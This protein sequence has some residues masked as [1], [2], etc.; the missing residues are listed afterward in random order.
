M[1]AADATVPPKTTMSK[2]HYLKIVNTIASWVPGG[3]GEDW[4]GDIFRDV[5]R[6]G[7]KLVLE[8]LVPNDRGV[9]AG[10]HGDRFYVEVGRD[11]ERGDALFLMRVEYA[12]LP[13]R[14]P[15]H[16][17]RRITLWP[18]GAPP[19]L[20]D[21]GDLF[22]VDDAHETVRAEDPLPE[23]TPLLQR[24]LA[25][26]ASTLRVAVRP[27]TDVH[28]SPAPETFLAPFRQMWT[29]HRLDRHIA[30]TTREGM[31][32]K[33]RT[34]PG[35]LARD[36]QGAL[37]KHFGVTLLNRLAAADP[38]VLPA[39]AEGLA[40][41]CISPE[42]RATLWACTLEGLDCPSLRRELHESSTAL[43]E[44]A[45]TPGAASAAWQRVTVPALQHLARQVDEELLGVIESNGGTEFLAVAQWAADLVFSEP[46]T[47]PAPEPPARDDGE[48]APAATPAGQADIVDQWVLGLRLPETAEV[49]GALQTLRDTA[50]ALGATPLPLQSID[51]LLRFD[52]DASACQDAI[53]KWAAAVGS[54]AA[55]PADLAEA[56]QIYAAL[57]TAAGDDA[58]SVVQERWI[59]PE[60]VAGIV[61]L[62]ERPE[63]DAVPDWLLERHSGSEVMARPATR[64]DWAERLSESGLRDDVRLFIDLYGSLNEPGAVKWMV[65]AQP[66]DDVTAHLH[67][68]HDEVRAFLDV[69]SPELRGMVAAEHGTL[70]EARDHGRRVEAL[71]SL[72]A[73]T[74]WTGVDEDLRAAGAT[75][76]APL[77][78]AYE[79]A[80]DFLRREIGLEDLGIDA[81][82]RRVAREQQ[83]RAQDATGQ[84]PA[85]AAITVQHNFVD[86]AAR[87]TLTEVPSN[88]HPYATIVVP[89]I[90]EA[91]QPGQF[92][93]E[94]EFVFADGVR[95]LWPSDWPAPTPTAIDV[96]P[97]KWRPHPT[98]STWQYGFSAQF[99][100]RRPTGTRRRLKVE[101]RVFEAGSRRPLGPP[102]TLEWESFVDELRPIEMRWSE[103]NEPEHV[104]AHP[105][106]PQAKA[107]EILGRFGRG[108]S[109]VVIAPR[110]FGKS[111]LVQYLREEAG[112]RSLLI[113]EPR[114]CT[115]YATP[116]GL[117]ADRFW[118]D[119]SD[120]F[121]DV[122][123]KRLKLQPGQAIPAAEAFDEIRKQAFADGHRAVVLLVDEAQLFFPKHD[124]QV[125]SRLKT[126]IETHLSRGEGK[127]PF[128]FGFIGLPSLHQ[129][130][131]ADLMAALSPNFEISE[132][133]ER[134]LTPLIG[135]MTS[136]LET[137]RGARQELARSAGNLLVLKV[138]I[139][140]LVALATSDQRRW[141]GIED[142]MQ[143][144][145]SLKEELQSG[146]LP[147]VASYIRDAL[148]DADRVEDW[149]PTASLPT[150]VAWST[151]Y[152]PGR[153][154]AEVMERV[155]A[156]LNQWCAQTYAGSEHGVKPTYT[157]E[158]VLRHLQALQERHVL[159]GHNFVSPLLPSW[160]RGL[161]RQAT[162]T[163]SF[164]TALFSGA[165]RRI[166]VPS[167]ASRV[168][169]GGEAEILRAG[170]FA[171][172]RRTLA[173]PDDRA[174]FLESAAMFAE[175]RKVVADREPGSDYIFE[176]QEMG[177]SA[178]NDAE[179]F[180]VYR[181]I[182]GQSLA[183]RPKGF[184]ADLVIDLGAKLSRGLALL[185]RH[186]V[187]HRDVSPRN[188]VLKDASD[189]LP[190]RP[191]LIDFGFAQITSKPTHTAMQ[192]DHY[193]PEVCVAPARWSRA[194]DIFALASTL[195]WLLHP[196]KRVPAL[197]E[198]LERATAADSGARLTADAF[199]NEFDDLELSRRHGEKR[200]GAWRDLWNIAAVDRHS[201]TLSQV[202][203]KLKEPLLNLALGDFADLAHR[204]AVVADF[205]NQLSEAVPRAGRALWNLSSD[206]TEHA[207]ALRMAGA[208]RNRLHHAGRFKAKE[209]LDAL[210]VFARLGPDGQR[211]ALL[212]TAGVIGSRAGLKNL[213]SLADRL[214][215]GD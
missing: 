125:G 105:I 31:L 96:A 104:R 59:T 3:A 14:Q 26:L 11:R 190:L 66:G 172:R 19:P 136:G 2:R 92:N 149:Q 89:L 114:V 139:H 50:A 146:R 99:P 116:V 194:A 203:N 206:V 197:D 154:E 110:R 140:K 108:S 23:P 97:V 32:L 147:D 8:P 40:S 98:L 187:L 22:G 123:G 63:L 138:L 200:D 12:R 101:A 37:L 24:S 112:G 143:V 42:T 103:A 60:D 117:D 124:R 171:Y 44:L 153:P 90:L 127:A 46:E 107:K 81:L 113:P 35:M 102:T 174:R 9:R 84:G 43:R 152:A 83:H 64:T 25:E 131:G 160:L 77:L 183:E 10:L 189:G 109:V 36:E 215:A 195:K 16:L 135:G 54:L 48:A 202:M 93:V 13:R 173:T 148:N 142:V 120:S 196:T 210:D 185:H 145:E 79:A 62:L 132:M 73:E 88:R 158:V 18:D 204:Q 192:G 162:G 144:E 119:V 177:L 91:E 193:A 30:P 70:A 100:I 150:A 199:V 176:F 121:V 5:F 47:P 137:T 52:A 164:K 182:D 69:V 209:Q 118:A 34:T 56:R 95:H 87:A 141:V 53:T 169:G 165:Q 76:R 212:Q 163:E 198:L 33:G 6:E 58:R 167:G 61:A 29:R 178:S 208:L 157:P 211:H 41:T 38:A 181:W 126:L 7:E 94:L 161:V 80:V 115:H 111:T 75:Q 168:D 175:L 74:L 21:V 201:P 20:D 51:A 4:R 27:G 1:T 166:K 86:R 78:A 155:V 55:L 156:T 122:I 82:R 15:T 68:W 191:V 57:V 67:A 184:S 130:A 106:G 213:V 188:I 207:D 159:D 72:L 214:L 17:T 65:P 151:A 186:S 133:D 170:E 205:L 128:L 28:A 85:E 45:T 49:A 134:E 39:V 179:A 129:R 71:R 180:Q